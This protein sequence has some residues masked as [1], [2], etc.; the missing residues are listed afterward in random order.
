MP[1]K[2]LWIG[3]S[4]SDEQRED[5]IKNGGKILSANVSQ[6]NLLDGLYENGV[7]LDSINSYRLPAYPK[8]KEKYIKSY[9]WSRYKESEDVS[10]SYLNLKYAGL[11]FKTRALVKS[12]KKWALKHKDDDVCV[13]VYSMHSPFMEAAREIK[14]IV[15]QARIVLI[16][17]DLPQYMDLG[18]NRLKTF[19]KKIDWIKIKALMKSVDKYV[20]YSKHMAEFLN[21]KDGIWT[22]M[23]GSVNKNDIILS[24]AEPI[25]DKVSVMYSGVCDLRYGIPEL[26]DAFKL[27]KE[28]NF[29]LW[30]TGAGNAVPLI[31]ERAK[32]DKR[33]K[34]Y[35]FLPSR[36]DLLKKQKQ[37][38][39]MIN[40][41]R[42]NE[43]A[44]KY[45]FPS[46]L[47]EY[48]LSGNPV[49]SFKIEGIPDEYFKHLIEMK[50][51]SPDC[52]AKAIEKVADMP[53]HERQR[54]GREAR[55]FVLQNKNNVKQ[56]EKILNFVRCKEL[57]E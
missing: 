9:S 30:I 2:F 18:M 28:E 57:D 14:R 27:I 32:E 48:M 54:F 23:E 6:N 8:Y 56:A 52:I 26:L 53:E 4:M 37:A 13:L 33:I 46:K 16:V 43:E 44:S 36:R 34:F 22:V 50:E 3:M 42:P 35:G 29:E 31:K 55:D 38:T 12:A 49:L 24:D 17:P 19:L 15:P 20:L 5:I 45:C 40:T 51:V 47:F 11:Y 1:E 10:V 7:V 25:R 39:M 21:L 41:R